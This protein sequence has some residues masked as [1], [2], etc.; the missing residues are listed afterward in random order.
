MSHFQTDSVRRRGRDDLR[1]PPPAQIRTCALTHT[2]PTSDDSRRSVASDKDAGHEV[3]ES[4]GQRSVSLDPK[5][6]P[7][8]GCGDKEPFDNEVLDPL[9]LR[10]FSFCA[11]RTQA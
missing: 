4:I 2:A 10:T 11:E 9:G 3:P 5:A 8:S 1:R 7:P 6:A